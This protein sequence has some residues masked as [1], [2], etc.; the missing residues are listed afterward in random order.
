MSNRGRTVRMIAV[1]GVLSGAVLLGGCAQSASSVAT[2]GS[3]RI[4]RDQYTMALSG[5][6]QVNQL[7]QESTQLTAE[8]VLAI[9]IQGIVADQVAQQRHIPLT[10]AT[11]DGQF[12]PSLYQIPDAHALVYAD[13]DVSIV[14][15]AIGGPGFKQALDNA[16]IRV[17]PR[18][19]TWDLQQATVAAGVG[20]LSQVAQNRPQ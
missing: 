9:M 17:N 13:A 4:T 5:A 2:V 1:A 12:D 10:D 19:G 20:S 11:R 7:P 14:V 8:D 16:G 3:T 15:K 18:F 6:S